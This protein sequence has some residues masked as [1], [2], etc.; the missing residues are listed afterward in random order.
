MADWCPSPEERNVIV[1]VAV[2]FVYAVDSFANGQSS[3]ELAL[4]ILI[5]SSDLPRIRSAKLQCRIQSCSRLL[6]R[7]PVINRSFQ[8]QGSSIAQTPS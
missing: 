1:G 4:Y 8:V 5:Y 7:I 3:I 2:T 6:R